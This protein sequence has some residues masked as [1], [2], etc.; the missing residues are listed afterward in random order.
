MSNY[1]LEHLPDHHHHLIERS[2]KE[3]D[4]G[5]YDLVGITNTN[6]FIYKK[7]RGSHEAEQFLR[8]LLACSHHAAVFDL[9]A[10]VPRIQRILGEDKKTPADCED[11]TCTG[12][13]VGH[14]DALPSPHIT[15][16]DGCWAFGDTVD[17]V[18]LAIAALPT[19]EGRERQDVLIALT[20]QS[21]Y[22]ASPIEGGDYTVCCGE[23]RIDKEAFCPHCGEV[24]A[25]GQLPG[26]PTNV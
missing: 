18:D 3:A 12:W 21:V 5:G 14:S 17:P 10:H 16:C 22:M 24:M 20:N 19:L 7:R 4:E 9:P 15:V 8:Y 25:P 1:R 13:I 6:T 11:P 26:S 2:L 23:Y